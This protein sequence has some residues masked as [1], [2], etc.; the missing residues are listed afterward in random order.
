MRDLASTL[1]SEILHGI[2]KHRLLSVAC[3][4]LFI[5]APVN[6]IV[7]ALWRLSG[8]VIP[9]RFGMVLC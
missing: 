4:Q 7:A 3:I 6:V 5:E 1:V 8:A 2:Y 9:G